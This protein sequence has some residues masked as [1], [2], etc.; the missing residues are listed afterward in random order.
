MQ[1]DATKI[2]AELDMFMP[3]LEAGVKL[4]PG[5]VGNELA[6]LLAA[7][8]NSSVLTPVIDL[9]NGF[10]TPKAGS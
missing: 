3:L 1:L 2:E 5:P 8:S 10:E 9:I 4:A 6:M 7:L